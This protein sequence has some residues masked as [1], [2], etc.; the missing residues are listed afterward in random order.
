MHD[1]RHPHA[2]RAVRVGALLELTPDSL[3]FTMLAASDERLTAM[4]TARESPIG[5]RSIVDQRAHRLCELGG[6]E[7]LLK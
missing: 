2:V 4:L 5:F 7:R 3:R 1:A 6:R